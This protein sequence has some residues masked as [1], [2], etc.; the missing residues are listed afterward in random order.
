MAPLAGGL[1]EYRGTND[2]LAFRVRSIQPVAQ[3]SGGM[4]SGS[5][6]FYEA[7]WLVQTGP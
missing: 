1:Q 2:D 5:T 6:E 7:S 4:T 3:P